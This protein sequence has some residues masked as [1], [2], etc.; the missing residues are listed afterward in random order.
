M[1]RHEAKAARI[2]APGPPGTTYA[3]AAQRGVAGG[4]QSRTESLKPGPARHER[5]IIV[6]R[7]EET[8]ASRWQLIK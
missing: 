3:A 8:P 2:N 4:A 5:E 6:S 1:Q 7:G